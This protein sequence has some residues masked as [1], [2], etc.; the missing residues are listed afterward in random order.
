MSTLS[1]TLDGIIKLYIIFI[2]DATSTY[3]PKHVKSLRTRYK[4]FPELIFCAYSS[5][6]GKRILIMRNSCF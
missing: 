3:L 6:Y 1:V 4:F 5:S 2:I